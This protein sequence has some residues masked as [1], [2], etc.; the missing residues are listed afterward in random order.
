MQNVTKFN[1]AT[2]KSVII[3]VMIVSILPLS[4]LADGSGTLPPPPDSSGQNNSIIID[5]TTTDSDTTQTEFSLIDS[6]TLTLYF[7]IVL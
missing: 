3:L 2:I 4:L 7:L 6:I 1:S 5:T